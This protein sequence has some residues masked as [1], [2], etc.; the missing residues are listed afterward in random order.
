[1][2][3]DHTARLLTA[4]LALVT[5]T[6]AR[7]QVDSGNSLPALLSRVLRADDG[8]ARDALLEKIEDLPG[9][10]I[11]GV[12]EA[13]RS[14]QLWDAVEPGSHE[15]QLANAEGG[16]TNVMV[17]V[18]PAYDPANAWPVIIG[19]HGTGGQAASYLEF[20]QALLGDRANEFL[21]VCPQEI[22]GDTFYDTLEESAQPMDLLRELRRR[23]HV[24]SDRVY[25]TGYSLGGHGTTFICLMHADQFAAGIPL[26][27]T[28]N[29]PRREALHPSVLPNLTSCPLLMVWGENDTGGPG[30]EESPVGGIAGQNERMMKLVARLAL[31]IEGIELAGVGHGN[32]RP[33][34]EK[35]V[36]YTTKQRVHFPKQ[37]SHVCRYPSQGHAYW[38]RVRKFLGK[39]WEKNE[40]P[41]IQLRQGDDPEQRATEAVLNRLRSFSGKIDGQRIEIDLERIARLEVLLSDE[42]IDLDE[43]IT[44]VV[45]GKTR[46]EGTVTRRIPVMLEEAARTWDVARLYDARLVV[47]G[48]GKVR[49]E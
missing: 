49:E 48:S 37:V 40:L 12:A 5:A 45:R 36:E 18:P 3:R 14:L 43:P 10:S 31:P 17:R 26:A 8:K 15:F 20:V 23:Y 44:V 39:P 47:Y 33:P 4:C 19:L 35:F 11:E 41:P 7:G 32:V 27:G 42:M 22:R 9:V 24:D 30:G 28:L 34:S 6:T 21:T 2:M 38:L 16:P 25:L 13:L 29:V 46:F 1:M